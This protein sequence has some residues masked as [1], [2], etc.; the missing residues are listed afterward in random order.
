MAVDILLSAQDFSNREST[1]M[2]AK[3]V[4]D[5]PTADQRR[6]TQ[7]NF[8]KIASVIVPRFICVRL[9]SSA[10]RLLFACI[11]VLFVSICSCFDCAGLL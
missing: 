3:K 7:I 4:R 1:R 6:L 10:I 5:K 11:R 8:S 9:S 2:N